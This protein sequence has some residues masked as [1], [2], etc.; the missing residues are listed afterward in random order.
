MKNSY[1][2]IFFTAEKRQNFFTCC[3]ESSVAKSNGSEKT[4]NMCIRWW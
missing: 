3:S 4:E 2:F 1:N